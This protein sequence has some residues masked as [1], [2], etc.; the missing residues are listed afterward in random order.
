MIL[1]TGATGNVGRSVVLQLA[2]RG[3]P[4]RALTRDKAR[5][6]D[7]AAM[8]EGVDIVEGDLSQPET[9]GGAFDGVDGMF[10]FTPPS[11]AGPIARLAGASGVRRVALLSSIATQKADPRTNAIAARHHGAEQA[12]MA[13]GMAWTILRPDSFA[14]N[15]LE[16]AESI[17]SEGVVRAA[18]GQSRRCPIHEDDVAAVAVCAL[19]DPSQSGQAHWLTG[20]RRISVQEQVAAIGRALGKDIRFEELSRD[21]ALAVMVQRLP[22]PVAERLLDYA[23]KSISEPPGLSD[24]IERILGRPPKDFM[25]WAV[26]HASDFR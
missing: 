25:Q 18:Y 5:D 1:V 20:P 24:A 4:V 7:R 21:E 8:P 19:L 23:R 3:I 26:D 13:S 14:S 9:L 12:V 22:R 11:G 17:R 10:L 6:K 2:A 15:A 16:W